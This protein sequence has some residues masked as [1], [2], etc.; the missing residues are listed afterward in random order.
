MEPITRNFKLTIF[1][2]CLINQYHSLPIRQ[3]EFTIEVLGNH[4]EADLVAEQTGCIT[5]WLIIGKSYASF[6][7]KRALVKYQSQSEIIKVML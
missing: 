6:G 3:N 2:F 4:V 1:I 5:Q 7:R